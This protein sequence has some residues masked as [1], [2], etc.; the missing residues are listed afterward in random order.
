MTE[1]DRDLGM[2]RAITRRDFL[3]GVSIAIGTSLVMPRELE[4]AMKAEAAQQAAA[5]N[6]D[7]YP[8]S[9]TG[10]RGSYP[11]AVE[12]VVQLNDGKRWEVADAENTNETYDL[13]VVGAGMSG[14][15]AAYFFRKKTAPTAKILILDNHDD[16]GGHAKRNEFNVGGRTLIA[17]GGTSFI[18]RPATFTAEGT[19]LLKELGINYREP[20]YK[21]D[22]GFYASKGLR[23]ATYFDKESFGVDRFVMN[24]AGQGGRGGGGGGGNSGPSQAFLSTTPLSA[25]VQKDLI[26]LYSDRR[27]Y[28]AG[29]TVE[30]KIAKLKSTSYQ[31]YLLNIVKIHPDVLKYYHPGGP[32]GLTTDTTSC[33]YFFARNNPGFAGLGVPLPAN[34]PSVLDQNRPDQSEPTQFH[35][36]EGNAGLARL[37]VRSLIPESMTGKTMIDA[38]MSRMNYDVLDN[39]RAP[40]RLRLSSA[41]VRVRNNS[42]DPA[43]A[44]GVDVAYLRG[45]KTYRVHAK[46]CVLACYNAVIPTMVPELPAAQKEALNLNVRG[47]NMSTNVAI[48]NWKVFEKLGISSVNCPGLSYPGYG[49]AALMAQLSLGA[50]RAPT[51]SEEP[52]VLSLGGGI[53]RFPGGPAREQFKKTRAALLQTSFETFERRIRTHLAR[54]LA[55]GSFDPA[56]E[57]AA[58][59][60]N[61]WPYGYAMGQNILYDPA[62]TEDETPWVRGR[63]RFGRITIA[64]SDAG[65]VCLTQCA[66]DQAY[67]AVDELDSRHMAWWHTI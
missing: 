33:W 7:N 36:P 27:D 11:A 48:R 22:S 29:M 25:E 49:G 30:Q 34:A 26:R 37:L 43:A 38:E 66:W 50:Y 12:P 44:S 56:T 16:F 14:L 40:V 62:W 54:V 4:A 8:P 18:E 35:F 46:G 65:A 63:K 59:T 2:D 19:E 47:V 64:N 13:V 32:A 55:D 3:N 42:D 61:R 57:I 31:D 17:K 67:R 15:A 58:I 52:I 45:G 39:P 1:S 28:L 10:L 21:Q 6:G 60:I 53:G 51:S 5:A 24:E 41:V 23:S 9:R 20:S